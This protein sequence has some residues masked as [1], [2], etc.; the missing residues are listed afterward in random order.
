MPGSRKGGTTRA[1]TGVAYENR[2][3]TDLS[4]SLRRRTTGR[5]VPMPGGT[6][7]YTNV[8][9]FQDTEMASTV[10]T[11]TPSTSVEALPKPSPLSDSTYPPSIEFCPIAARDVATST[12]GAGAI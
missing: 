3:G 1:T 11:V 2:I 4:P 7:T 10:P 12:L 5:S 9:L 8:L 6:T